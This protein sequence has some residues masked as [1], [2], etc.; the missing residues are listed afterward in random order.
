MFKS[1][2]IQD[3]HEG[4]VVP[5][6]N[7]EYLVEGIKESLRTKTIQLEDSLYGWIDFAK[8]L[9]EFGKEEN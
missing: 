3:K 8:A 6:N 2:F 4:I 7:T 5:A 1:E 9:V